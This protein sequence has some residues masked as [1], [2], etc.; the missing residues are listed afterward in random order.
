MTMLKILDMK[1]LLYI[2]II[3]DKNDLSNKILKEKVSNHYSINYIIYHQIQF[4]Q[5]AST[6]TLVFF[7]KNV[8]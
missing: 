7:N 4:N 3:I 5:I 2:Y 8:Q 6:M 1:L